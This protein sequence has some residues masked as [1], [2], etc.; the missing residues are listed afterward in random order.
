M[1]LATRDGNSSLAAAPMA[2]VSLLS[3]DE[4]SSQ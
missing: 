2:D 3:D 1:S 4:M